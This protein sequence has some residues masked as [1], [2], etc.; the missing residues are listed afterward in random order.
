MNTNTEFTTMELANL[1][2]NE[3]NEKIKPENI[4]HDVQV[5]DIVGTYKGDTGASYSPKHII[6]TGIGLDANNVYNMYYNGTNLNIFDAEHLDTSNVTNLIG[7]FMYCSNLSSLEELQNWNTINVSNMKNTFGGQ[8]SITSFH[9]LENWDV[10]N[11]QSISNFISS[12]HNIHTTNELINWDLSNVKNI[13]TMF[14]YGS[15]I[16]LCMFA[17]RDYKGVTFDCIVSSFDNQKSLTNFTNCN[18]TNCKISNL[19]A[20]CINLQNFSEIST[21][22]FTDCNISYIAG[23]RDIPRQFR[24]GYTM[25]GNNIS[26]AY[27]YP[28]NNM[29]YPH[30]LQT[31]GN[32]DITKCNAYMMFTNQTNLAQVENITMYNCNNAIYMFSNCSNITSIAGMEM[33]FSTNYGSDYNG[34]VTYMFYNC[35]K[36]VDATALDNWTYTDTIVSGNVRTINTAYMFYNC[37]NLSDNSIYAISNFLCNISNYILRNCY[38]L[39]NQNYMSIFCGTNINVQNVL[40]EDKINELTS[41]GFYF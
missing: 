16:D 4:R 10:S 32:Y 33:H 13:N 24:P 20:S 5:F 7:T 18:F 1:I 26:L 21:W 2:L 23:Y 29:S 31:T 28:S 17:N 39:N 35:H 19:I 14:Y 40:S 11:V 8:S 34:L 37:N 25:H 6:F 36:L 30:N 9:G 12:I 3:K 27:L 41:H 22:N 15:D 38:N